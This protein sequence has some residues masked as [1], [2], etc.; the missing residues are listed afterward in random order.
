MSLDNQIFPSPPLGMNLRNCLIRQSNSKDSLNLAKDKIRFKHL[1]EENGIAVPRTYY[2]IHNYLDLERIRSFP[3]EFVIKPN[4]GF[5]G[6]GIIVLKKEGDFF[7]TPSSHRYTIKQILFHIRQILNGEFSGHLEKDA[8]LIE[9]RIYPSDKLVFKDAVGL[10]D[11]RLFCYRSVP[12]MAV[13]RYPTLKSRGRANLSQGA[14]GIGLDLDT[15]KMTNIWSKKGKRRYRLKDLGIPEGYSVPKWDE[16]KSLAVKPSQIS[17][18]QISGVDLILDSKDRILILEIN[19]RPG[20]EIQNVNGQ[21][22]PEFNTSDKHAGQTPPPRS[23]P[24]IT[25]VIRNR[26][27]FGQPG[28]PRNQASH[29][30]MAHRCARQNVSLPLPPAA[31]GHALGYVEDFAIEERPKMT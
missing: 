23:W 5:G 9:E 13:L 30:H 19:G 15:G 21:S 6:N 29:H 25:E 11:I 7:V 3:D 31:R 26:I 27:F 18:L 4:Q 17:K 8:A 1:L 24:R 22:L 14:I 20:L 12:V 16:I 10:P 28:A 2:E